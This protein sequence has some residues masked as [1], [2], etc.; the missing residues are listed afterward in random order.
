MSRLLVKIGSDYVTISKDSSFEF[1]EKSFLVDFSRESLQEYVKL[2]KKHTKKDDSLVLLFNL[3]DFMVRTFDSDRKDEEPVKYF[4]KKLLCEDDE[5]IIKKIK[6]DSYLIL[7]AEVLQELLFGFKDFKIEGIYA[8]EVVNALNLL[9]TQDLVYIDISYQNFSISFNG[10]RFLKRDLK[11]TLF[12]FVKKCS[13]E[14]HIDFNSTVEHL[15]TSY[16]DIKSFDDL[17]RSSKPA[18]DEIR[19]FLDEVVSK[20]EETLSY[21]NI[22]GGLNS[23]KKFYI[24]GD[25]L[26]FEVLLRLLKD[27]FK[28][29]EIVE[30]NRDLKLNNIKKID[31][32]LAKE[33]ER[34]LEDLRLDIDGVEFRDKKRTFVFVDNSF[35]D[36]RKL[37]K[38][39]KEKLKEIQKV[40]V[41]RKSSTKVLPKKQKEK[42]SIL[43]M[44][45]AE[46]KEHFFSKKEPED[47]KKD[48]D[49]NELMQLLFLAFLVVAGGSYFLVNLA[50]DEQK[51]FKATVSNLKS[52]ID[53]FGDLANKHIKNENVYIDK[54]VDKIFW[55]RKFIT[56]ANNMP[57]AI[58][59]SSAELVDKSETVDGKN[60]VK[61]SLLL[62]GRVLPSSIGHIEN[63]AQYMDKLLKADIN[64]QRDFVNV[65]FMGANIVE[66]Y[67][68]KVVNFKLECDFEKNVHIEEFKKAQKEAKD[69]SIMENIGEIKKS[70]KAKIEA[71]N[72][73]GK[74]NE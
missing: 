2:L 67:G 29:V 3:P 41:R 58:W 66:E 45:F 27:R 61:K 73:I 53:K 17:L 34:I 18:R 1:I 33:N 6:N 24:N 49:S 55:T 64:F 74:D 54:K 65:S 48:S 14:I 52:K 31:I 30:V 56:I 19:N 36:K 25:I 37:N 44:N 50:L 69:R 68:Y 20:I 60:V 47:S 35:Q 43:Q 28:N 7:K 63:I 26:N 5:I 21:F 71:L 32:T 40:E 10:E 42:K 72:N 23:V 13:D 12:K 22:T 38:K 9:K 11:D 46:L 57:N 15:R 16:E 70:Q 51:K 39:S 59:L 8:T 62:E 4:S